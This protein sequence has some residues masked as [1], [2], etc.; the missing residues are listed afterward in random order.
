MMIYTSGTTGQPKG[1]LHGA[2]R[3]ARPSA[4][5]RDAARIL[6][7]AG[8]RFWTP[9]DWAWAGGLLDCCCRACITACRWSARKFDKFDPRGGLRADGRTGVRNA[10]IP[11]TALRM[12]RAVANPR[13]RYDIN[14]RTHRLGRRVA[15]RRDLRWG[16]EAL[17]L[18]INEFYGQTECN[19]VLGSCAAIGVVEAR[20]D[21]QA[22]AGPRRRGDPRRTASRCEPGELGQIAVR[23][24]DPV[25]FLEYW[26]KPEA[27]RGEIH[28]RLDDDRR[29]GHASTRRA[30]SASSAAT[31]T[32][33][34]RPAT[35]SGRARSRIA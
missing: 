18:T 32:S 12:L 25:M 5:R 33:S 10:F 9:A 29:P 24:P 11:P 14:L 1:A 17:G 19:L 16:R 7:A 23:R 21:R 13:G 2:S 6:P 31:T 4:G 28:R 22:G 35:A 15:R 27:T 30:T 3:P 20:R 8:D 26:D 34:P